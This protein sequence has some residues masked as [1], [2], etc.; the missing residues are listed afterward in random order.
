[1]EEILVNASTSS[2]ATATRP[3]WLNSDPWCYRL[4]LIRRYG[5]GNSHSDIVLLTIDALAK[6]AI[7]PLRR[8]LA[9]EPGVPY[10]TD[11]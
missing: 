6:H 7:L 11:R 2:C 8:R 1:M 4:D 3:N 10:G 5:E 9:R